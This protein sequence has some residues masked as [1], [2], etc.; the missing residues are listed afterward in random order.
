MATENTITV[1]GNLTKDPDLRYTQAGVAVASLSVA[2]NRR[3][4]NKQTNEWED[5]LDGYFDINI[6]RDHAENVAESLSKGDRVLVTGR[7][8]KRSYDDREGQT[9]WVTEIEAD[10]ICPSLKWAR[11][12]VNRV[13]RGGGSPRPASGADAPAPSEPPTP[14]D[15]PF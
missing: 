6:W 9:R 8:I 1:I 14:D 12:T 4:M 2:V 3:M 10:E 13:G 15:V 7:L 11:V 5:K